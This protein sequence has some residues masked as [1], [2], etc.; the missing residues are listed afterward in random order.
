MA[1]WQE[2]AGFRIVGTI[3]RLFISP[4]GKF[5]AVRLKVNSPP[6]PPELDMKCFDRILIGDM[7]R[8]LR[9]GQRVQF[10]GKIE[11]EKLQDKSRND[12]KVDGYEVWIPALRPAKFEVEG[13]S[14][15]PAEKP[16]EPAAGTT[17]DPF[18]RERTPGDDD[19][20]PM[21]GGSDP[22]GG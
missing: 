6:H 9:V 10:T 16:T 15:K 13:S 7:Q 1:S 2:G 17:D 20:D 11:S 14:R 12:V 22:F 4:T 21:G 5:A 8:D 3:K 18:K 19:G